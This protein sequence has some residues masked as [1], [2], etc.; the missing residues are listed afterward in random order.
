MQPDLWGRLPMT[1]YIYSYEAQ[2]NNTTQNELFIALMPSGSRD[3]LCTICNVLL[4]TCTNVVV[5]YHAL[6]KM[7]QKLLQQLILKQPIALL[8]NSLIIDTPGRVEIV[9]KFN[10]DDICSGDV[11]VG[12]VYLL[13]LLLFHLD[14][15]IASFPQQAL[16]PQMQHQKSSKYILALAQAVD[17]IWEAY[18][19]KCSVRSLFRLCIPQIR[20][21]MNSLSDSS[22]LALPVPSHV[23][24][25]LMYQDIADVIGEA[26]RLWSQCLPVDNDTQ[27][28]F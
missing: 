23:C 13:S 2:Y 1:K 24:K 9:I 16:G 11:S 19:K 6:S 4:H 10:Q 18:R 26:W 12:N 15:D 21:S 8:I 28:K 14:C 3:F 7:L 22:F 25:M 20:Q 17:D 27:N 5:K